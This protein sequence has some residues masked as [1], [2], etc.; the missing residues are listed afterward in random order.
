M[1]RMDWSRS[2]VWSGRRTMMH[3]I[4]KQLLDRAGGGEVRLECDGPSWES[5]VSGGDWNSGWQKIADRPVR[6]GWNIQKIRPMGDCWRSGSDRNRTIADKPPLPMDCAQAG[7]GCSCC[8][9]RTLHL[10]CPTGFMILYPKARQ[11]G[12]K[13][14]H[15]GLATTSAGTTERRPGVEWRHGSGCGSAH[16]GAAR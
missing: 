12:L 2:K 6:S 11:V 15:V 4:G 13:Y 5:Q 14:G 16:A 8:V 1:S 10:G 3:R 7:I 9:E